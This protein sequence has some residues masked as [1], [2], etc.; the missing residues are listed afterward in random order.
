MNIRRF[1][2]KVERYM[3]AA[4]FAEAGEY[5]TAVYIAEEDRQRER[6]MKRPTTVQ[7]E[8]KRLD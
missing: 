2:E 3:A 7:R 1:F 6:E 8:T 5:A 4:A